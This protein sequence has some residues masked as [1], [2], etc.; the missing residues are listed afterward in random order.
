MDNLLTYEAFKY[1][2]NIPVS[3]DVQIDN[4]NNLIDFHQKEI[5]INLLGYELYSEFE[6]ALAGTPA[7]K[8]TN[9]RDGATFEN[10]NGQTVNFEGVA[11]MLIYLIYFEYYTSLISSLSELGPVKA[12][13][14]NSELSVNSQK[15][16]NAY[17]YGVESYGFDYLGL[18]SD[19]QNEVNYSKP[20]NLSGIDNAQITKY[21]NSN[22]LQL[23]ASAYNFI[24]FTNKTTPNTYTNW[25]FKSKHYLNS[26][27][28]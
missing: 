26:V 12:Q 4:L 9:L 23:V 15:L 24:Y 17:N 8:W 28:F 27:G 2:F 13:N 11:N 22:T 6:T 25:I 19:I 3:T 14:K 5:L 10:D 16:A 21:Y 1:P 20:I 18:F 7:A